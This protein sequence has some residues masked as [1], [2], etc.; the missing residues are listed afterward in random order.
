MKS[1]SESAFKLTEGVNSES[2]MPLALPCQC[3]VYYLVLVLVVT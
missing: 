1:E 2:I 3:S